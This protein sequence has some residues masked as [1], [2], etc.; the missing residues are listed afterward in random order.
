MQVRSV[1]ELRVGNWLKSKRKPDGFRITLK[2]MGRIESLKGDYQPI[3]LSDGW[4]DKFAFRR[5]ATSSMKHPLYN[6]IG[7]FHIEMERYFILYNEKP[8]GGKG[9]IIARCEFVHQLQNWWHSTV[10]KELETK[11]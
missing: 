7:H 9:V 8:D 2:D 3:E 1:N 4:M 5:F 6:L 11:Q 10:G